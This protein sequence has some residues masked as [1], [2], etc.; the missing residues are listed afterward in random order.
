MR[1]SPCWSPASLPSRVPLSSSAERCQRHDGYTSFAVTFDPTKKPNGSASG[2]LD[3]TGTYSY[4]IAPDNGAVLPAGAT[5]T[6]IAAPIWSLS[7]TTPGVVQLAAMDQNADGKSDEN[8]L[9]TPFT[10]LTPGDAYVAPMPQPT[11]PFTFTASNILNPP[12]D[13]NTLP[14]ILP[15]P[16][17]VSTSVPNG[18]GSDNLV[19]DGTNSSLNV[20][21]SQPI[22]TSTFDPGQVL[23]IMGPVGSISGPQDF[24]SDSTLQ[25]IPSATTSGPGVLP[26]TL[27]I[28][29]FDGTFTVADITV[30]LNAELQ[31]GSDVT[32]VL[33]SPNGTQVPLFL[34]VGANGATFINTTFDDA[35]ENSIASGADLVHRIV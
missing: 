32:A 8:P 29:S 3:F 5:P 34:S 2:I 20:T 31:A 4:V 24:S 25:T 9:T 17:V 7:T 35:A 23:Q 33:I 18:T 6:P 22:Q 13:Q 19:L 28:P 16:Y 11:V 26:S 27:T 21:F 1:S 14:L 10:G 15:G 12:F 30:Q